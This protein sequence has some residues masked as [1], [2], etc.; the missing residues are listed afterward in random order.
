MS[1]SQPGTCPCRGAAGRPA[2][3]YALLSPSLRARPSVPPS[4]SRCLCRQH[5]PVQLRAPHR[6]CQEALNVLAKTVVFLRNLPSFCQLLPQDQRL[7][8]RG[9]WGPLFLLGLAQD[10]VTFE[11]AEAPASSILKKILLEEPSSA[12]RD[13]LPDRPQPSL[14]AVQWLQC[15][16]ESFWSLELGPKEYAYLKGTILFNPD[17]PGLHAS[18]HIWH[19]QQ[20]AHQALCEV[21][22]P[23]YPASQGRLARVFLTASTLTSI[24]SSLLGDLFFRPIVGDVDIAGLLE[25]MLLLSRPAPAQAEIGCRL[26]RGW[27]H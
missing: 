8:L 3:L 14:A 1:S 21:L 18:L 15:C 12:G 23:W 17:M 4:R 20:E 19:L 10:T 13:Q 6:T 5:R 22:E 24:P 9:C 7:L 25:D 16:L 26:G 27:Q 2:I 11:V